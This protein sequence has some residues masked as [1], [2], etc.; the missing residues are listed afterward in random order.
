MADLKAL[1][2]R[3]NI[4]TWM[5]MSTRSRI[6][7]RGEILDQIYEDAENQE[8]FETSVELKDAMRDF[9]EAPVWQSYEDWCRMRDNTFQ[10]LAQRTALR[11]YALNRRVFF[12]VVRTHR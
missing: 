4:A 1:D 12:F 7:K 6:V 2:F 3:T 8:F 10:N 5:T 11:Q 9:S